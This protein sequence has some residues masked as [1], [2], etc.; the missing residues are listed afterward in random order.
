VIDITSHITLL[1][2]NQTDGIHSLNAITIQ[3]GDIMWKV[4]YKFGLGTLIG[5]LSGFI[6][7]VFALRN[8]SNNLIEEKHI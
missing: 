1:I 6:G 5:V 8:T 7:G 4:N 3:I 2:P